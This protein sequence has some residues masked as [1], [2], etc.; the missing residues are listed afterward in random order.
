M[1]FAGEWWPFPDGTVR[2]T[3]EVHVRA[4]D[5]MFHSARFLLDTGA[6][7]T[8]FSAHFMQSLG[9]PTSTSGRVLAGVGGVTPHVL[10]DAEYALQSVDG[11]FAG[12]VRRFAAFL[13]P[14]TTDHGLLGRDILDNFDVVVSRPRNEVWLLSPDHYYQI[15]TP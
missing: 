10:L 4:A 3:V 15:L 2:P 7:R 1:L 12:G 6:D 8:I 9:L 5:G 13:N 11:Q 14:A